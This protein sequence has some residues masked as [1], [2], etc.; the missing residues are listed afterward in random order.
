MIQIVKSPNKTLSTR[1]KE[2]GAVND[3]V[4]DLIAKMWDKLSTID[5][6][7]LAAPQI[8][9]NL[10]VAVIGFEPTKEQIKK[11]PQLRPVPKMVIINPKIIHC[12]KQM[13]VEKEG[14]LS[15]ESKEI[16]VP[17]YEKIIVEYLDES[18]KTKKLKARGYLARIIQHEIDHLEG[19]VITHYE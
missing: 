7:G 15:V 17:R 14:C 11:N 1:S 6:V 10:K 2:V 18:G 12:S 3:E 8:G 5:G 9:V 19:R 16:A 4:R 13:G